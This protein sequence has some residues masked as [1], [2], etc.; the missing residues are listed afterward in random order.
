VA[1]LA[2]HQIGDIE[3]WAQS[4]RTLADQLARLD[5]QAREIAGEEPATADADTAE[6]ASP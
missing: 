1:A 4:L 6:E 3:Q 2:R 5:W